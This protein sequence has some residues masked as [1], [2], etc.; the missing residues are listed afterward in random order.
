MPPKRKAKS[1][2]PPNAASAAKY[3]DASG[4]AP[5]K[6]SRLSKPD[7]KADEI[8]DGTKRAENP[9]VVTNGRGL[10]DDEPQFDHSR[11]EER[12]GIVD[13]RFYPAEMSNER[14]AMYNANEIP[15]PIEVL[16]ETLEKTKV[17]REEAGKAKGDAVVHWFKRDLRVHDNTALSLA[18]KMAKEKGV[19]LIG[20]WILS[21]QDWEAHLVS[22]PKCDFELRSVGILQKELAKLGIPLHMEVLPERKN[23]SKLVVKLCQEWGVKNVFCNLEYEPDELRR[24]ERLVRTCLENA[25]AFNPYHDDCIVPPG[26]LQTGTGKQYAVY[27]PFF[28]S[29]VAHLHAHPDLLQERPPP[30]PNPPGFQTGRFAH[31]FNEPVPEVPGSK[32]IDPEFKARLE[33]LY[34]AGE[35]AAVSRLEHFLTEKIGAYKDT[36]NFPAKNSTAVVSVHHAAGT[37]AARTSVRMAR[38]V[39]STKK[40]DGGNEGIRSWISEVAWRDFYRHV[41]VHWPYI[42]MHKP[43]KYE[44]TNIRWDYSPEHFTAWTE[45]RTGYPIVDAAMRCVRSTAY[46][47]NRLR[48]I[49]ASFI[50]KHLLLDWRLGEQY[51]MTH[52]IDGDFASNNG[53]WG[54]C[55]ST[56]VDPQ[57]Y[58]RVFNPWLQ[59]A[60]F[61]ADGEF[62][63]KWV[64]ELRD[65]EGEGVHNPYEK[66]GEAARIAERN[67][68]PRPIVEHKFARER[69]LRRYK[70]GIG[71]ETA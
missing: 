62:I 13:R 15:R 51:F 17:A 71:R 39:N 54:F 23:I 14:C 59:S 53:G 63:R 36:R 61:D 2:I 11:P 49:A 1:Q 47:H 18:S 60:K 42:A 12:A 52:L 57:P 6:R 29:W 19:G 44:Y 32:Q 45:G 28:R 68:Y 66:G 26:T 56:G 24:E 25:I 3:T 35:A 10:D 38:D 40:L 43:F 31:F 70:E 4:S 50:A 58:F 55:T 46:M 30:S 33:Q 41:L 21:P 16:N 34:P 27:S 9:A 48:M 7:P 67:G 64:K 22:P 69:C 20:L 5:N 8:D 37:L 65:V